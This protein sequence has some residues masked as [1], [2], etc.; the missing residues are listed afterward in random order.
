MTQPSDNPYDACIDHSPAIIA[1]L[2]CLVY[3]IAL[4][5]AITLIAT[6]LLGWLK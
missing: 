6:R 1:Y 4:G 3:G 5:S 2:G